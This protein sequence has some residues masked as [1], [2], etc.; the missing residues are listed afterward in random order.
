MYGAAT[1][2]NSQSRPFSE[3]YCTM[4][5]LTHHRWWGRVRVRG[6]EKQEERSQAPLSSLPRNSSL[7]SYVIVAW[8]QV[9]QVIM[10]I[11]CDACMRAIFPSRMGDM[12]KKEE[13]IQRDS[14]RLRLYGYRKIFNI[15]SK[16]SHHSGSESV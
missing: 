1:K 5:I 12:Q 8:P 14:E 3:I 6:R 15:C 11:C 7:H 9:F 16:Y 4:N 2:K 13:H 10:S